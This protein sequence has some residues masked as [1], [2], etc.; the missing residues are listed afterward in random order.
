MVI[1]ANAHRDSIQRMTA[2]SPLVMDKNRLQLQ[3]RCAAA[4]EKAEDLQL[5]LQA[6]I[7]RDSEGK[8]VILQK[9]LVFFAQNLQRHKKN[10][11]NT[12]I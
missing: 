7:G 10:I 5:D 8:I 3:I 1:A 12:Q 9:S 6:L 2:I 4:E 11:R